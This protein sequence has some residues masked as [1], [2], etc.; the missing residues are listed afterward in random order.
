MFPWRLEEMALHDSGGQSIY[1]LPLI[2]P[3]KTNKIDFDID[4][5]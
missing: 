3:G 5:C 4:Q 1:H 2:F